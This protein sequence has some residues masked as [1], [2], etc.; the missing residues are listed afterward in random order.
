[1]SP[2]LQALI[3]AHRGHIAAEKE[4]LRVVMSALFEREIPDLE[5]L[6]AVALRIGYGRSIQ[7]LKHLW[8]A[9]MVGKR[10]GAY[11]VRPTN[12]LMRQIFRERFGGKTAISLGK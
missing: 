2:N 1:M 11:Y 4:E 3:E 10:D 6:E 5:V 9:S 8:T 7:V 12:E